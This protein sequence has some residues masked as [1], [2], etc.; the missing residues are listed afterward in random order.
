MPLVVVGSYHVH[1]QRMNIPL[2]LLP[3]RV[4]IDSGQVEIWKSVM[5][6]CCFYHTMWLAGRGEIFYLFHALIM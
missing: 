5:Q 3:W 6:F 1:N 4:N 2:V